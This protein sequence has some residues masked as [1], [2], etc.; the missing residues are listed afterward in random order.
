M[1]N[2]FPKENAEE[3]RRLRI[4]NTTKSVQ[5]FEEDYFDN[6]E[7]EYSYGGLLYDGRFL[8]NVRKLA[9]YYRLTGHRNT[10]VLDYG[11]AKGFILTEFKKCGVGRV[12]G[13]DISK[14]ALE[15]A[16]VL[17]KEDL[18][19]LEPGVD[20]MHDENEFSLTMC[21]E[22]LP[23]L[24]EEEIFNL[25]KNLNLW[26]NSTYIY[27]YAV[28]DKSMVEP[29]QNAEQVLKTIKPSDW[30][31]QMFKD[32]EYTGDYFIEKVF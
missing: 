14:Y 10:S 1:M 17:V 8:P 3:K 22:V 19:L 11:C 9:S 24:D 6:K 31:H 18:I 2:F 27:T 15:N 26:G 5:D 12:L 32:A 25:I 23:Y 4:K 13:Y 7:F 29:L 20:I 16:H 21:K 28:D 30:W